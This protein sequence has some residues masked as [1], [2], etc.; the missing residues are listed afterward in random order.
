MC[1]LRRTYLYYTCT[2][3]DP[4]RETPRDNV[5]FDRCLLANSQS[6]RYPVCCRGTPAPAGH[7]HV[8]VHVHGQGTS[9]RR[10]RL[11]APPRLRH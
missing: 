3:P 10:C 4:T 1:R 8:H 6:A 7:S 9:G 11:L 5:S 2:V